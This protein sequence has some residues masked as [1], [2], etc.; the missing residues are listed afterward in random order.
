[1][2]D[3]GPGEQ[4]MMKFIPPI[5]RKYTFFTFGHA[6]TVMV[7]FERDERED[8]RIAADDDSGFDRNAVIQH[9]LV[10]HRT[11]KVKLRMY[12]RTAADTFGVLVY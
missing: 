5:T 3:L 2:L 4:A 1:M 7:L 8:I 11:Y 6:D 12:S 9:R 10:A